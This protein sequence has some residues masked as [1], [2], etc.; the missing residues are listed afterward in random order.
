LCSL[1]YGVYPEVEITG[2]TDA[3]FPYI[4]VHME[5]IIFELLKNAMR[6]TV[7]WSEASK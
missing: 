2:A 3:V 5:Y 7:E 4:P 6:A 1:N